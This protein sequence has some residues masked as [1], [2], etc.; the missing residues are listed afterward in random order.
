MKELNNTKTIYIAYLAI[1]NPKA[2]TAPYDKSKYVCRV[3]LGEMR[4]FSEPPP[5]MTQPNM[6]FIDP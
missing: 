1:F 5:P 3:I 6:N 2:I 4:G